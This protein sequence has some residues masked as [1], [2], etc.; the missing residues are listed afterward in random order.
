MAFG[1]NTYWHLL[2][3]PTSTWWQYLLAFADNTCWQY[4]L[5]FE[6]N[7]Y[8]HLLA[9][10]TDICWQYL[11]TF[12]DNTYWHLLTILT[13]TWWQYL[14]AF[15]GTSRTLLTVFAC[16][17]FT[18]STTLVCTFANSTRTRTL[19]IAQYLQIICCVLKTVLCLLNIIDSDYV[20]RSCDTP[21]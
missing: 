5:A 15:A 20:C 7:T 3:I 4:L 13:G 16:I 6:D 2:T 11:L 12:A 8:W 14:L 21:L 18:T 10:L 9:I 17:S 19:I 1:D